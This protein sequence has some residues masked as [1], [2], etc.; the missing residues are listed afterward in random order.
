VSAG[1]LL[2]RA[3]GLSATDWAVFAEAAV[4]AVLVEARLQVQPL[5][6]VVAPS[7][8]A[9]P[10]R[11]NWRA[12]PTLRMAQLAAWPYRLLPLP[13]SCLRRSLVLAWLMRRRGLDAA[14]RFG[15]RRESSGIEAHA[16]VTC[17]G[18]DVGHSSD[19]RFL[20][21]GADAVAPLSRSVRW[22]P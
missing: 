10:V 21:L 22:S 8:P 16:W 6:R 5:S 20:P 9:R 18:I 12:A 7:R 1:D 13:S 4:L 19:P 11:A 17:D 14:V 3:R 15:V 2:R